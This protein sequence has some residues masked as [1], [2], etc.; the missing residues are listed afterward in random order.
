MN[1]SEPFI[2]RPVMTTLLMV[3]V[4]VMGIMAYE[5][6]PVSNLPDVTYPSI[7][8]S[9]SF[10]GASP[11]TMANTVATP[12]EKEFM[13]IPGIT[14]VT[15]TNTLGS[16]SIILEF[17]IKKS[18]DSAAQDVEAAISRAKSNLPPDLPRD[19]TYK[20][21][22]P[23]DSPIIYITLTSA[24]MR[25]SDLYTY[26]NTFIGQRIS[27]LEGVAQV[28]VYGSP[29]AVRVQVD[30]G[31]L[32]TNRVTLK[33]VSDAIDNANQNLPTGQLDGKIV[34]STIYANGQLEKGAEYQPVIIAYRNGRPV[35]IKDVGQAIDSLQNDRQSFRYIDGDINQPAVVIAVQRQPGANTIKVADSIRDLLPG[36]SKQLPGSVDMKVIFDRSDSIKESV[37]EVKFT[38]VLA[39]ILVVGVIF[40][41]LGKI[42]DTIIPSLVLPMSIVATF[43]VMYP[44]GFSIDN[45]SL[46]ALTLAIG[47]II[48]DAIVVLE[49]IVRHVE[50]GETPWVAALEGSK[51]ISFTILSMTL[52]LVAVFIPMLFMAGLI[53]KIFQEFAMTLTIITLASGVISLTL[54][55]M[56]CSRFIPPRGELHS[57]KFAYYS[58][59]ANAWMLRH[60][61]R[62]L[63]WVLHHRLIVL[64]VGIMSVLFCV[65]FFWIL[66]TDFIPDD[67]IGFIIGYNEAQQGTSSNRMGD[68]QKEVIEAIKSDP[69]VKTFISIAAYPQYRQGINFIRLTPRNT[70]KPANQ[71]IQDLYVRLGKI[72]GVNTY[73]KNVPLI[74]LSVGASTKGPYQ[75]ILQSLNTEELY[76]SAEALIEKMRS[77]TAY[78]QGVTSDLE[79]KTPQLNVNIL[80]DKSY[81]LGVNAKDIEQALLFAYSGNRVSRIQTPIDQYDVILELLREYQRDPSALN[82]LYLRSNTSG[83]MVPLDAVANWKEGIGPASINHLAQFPAVTITFNAAPGVPLG[84]ALERLRKHAAEHFTPQV[85]GAVKGAAE[86]FESSI[87]SSGYLLLVAV[88]AIYIVLGILYES[89]IHPLTILSTLPPAIFG[90]L[91]TLYLFGMPLSLYAYLGLILL[92]GIV[93]KNGIMM[94]D[95]ALD[96]I[97]T[98]GE[99]PENSIYDACV[100]RF[101]PIMMTTM[102]AIMGAIPIALGVGAGADARRPLGYV[103]IGGLLFSQIITLF[104]TPVIYLYL[105]RFNEKFT[106]K[107][108][109]RDFTNE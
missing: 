74:D 59:Q 46:L 90:A 99:S 109:M 88:F 91:F 92:I 106:F 68:Y 78:F 81:T 28:L 32:A 86:T 27:M 43:A 36:L 67:D 70:R 50:N 29:Y 97:R 11:Q 40:L 21:V 13:T 2:V 30:P 89:F 49:N 23:S 72:P 47:F 105:E 75:Y 64:S 38:L 57:G 83:Q 69:S 103:I 18:M 94:V 52:S 100:V 93:K 10:P 104:L 12:L 87:K 53:G 22:N 7:N 51:Q 61:E 24:T 16:S 48:D 54:T 9:V 45:L 15:S 60:Y 107:Q 62:G 63:K 108:K 5:W 6:L 31:L 20:K 1:L 82:L 42:R 19:P 3:A 4:L 17:E 73:L 80:R 95:Y 85:T 41:Y 79:I 84:T 76:Q 33:E 66:P 101:R 39:F 25:R 71:V 56:L 26:A 77:D 102:A 34:A 8:V 96:N 14:S 58:T 44:L 65:Y 37:Y 55:P 98:K 35:R